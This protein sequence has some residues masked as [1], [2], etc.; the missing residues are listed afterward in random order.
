MAGAKNIMALKLKNREPLAAILE[1]PGRR[2]ELPQ[3]RTQGDC[4]L[5]IA[6]CGLW[7]DERRAVLTLILSSSPEVQCAT[8]EKRAS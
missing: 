4:G 5:R 6:D 7:I 1:M 8:D 2:R 3:K